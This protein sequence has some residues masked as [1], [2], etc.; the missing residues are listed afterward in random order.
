MNKWEREA[1]LEKLSIYINKPDIKET[2]EIYWGFVKFIVQHLKK[3]EEVRCPHFGSFILSRMKPRKAII[4]K[5]KE[6]K[7]VG[8]SRFVKFRPDYK[9]K[10][11]LNDKDKKQ[12]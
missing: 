9:V 8:E 10:N 3:E 4:P 5:T 6:R 7:F 12:Q 2:E 1:F 11:Y